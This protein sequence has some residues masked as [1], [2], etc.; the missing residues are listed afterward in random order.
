VVAVSAVVNVR[1]GTA[2]Q[3]AHRPEPDEA[4]S[5]QDA[6]DAPKLA[7]LLTRILR[8]VA[9]LKRPFAPRRVSF[10]DLTV[11]GTG[12][13]KYRLPHGFG[14]RVHWFVADWSG[15]A[16]GAGLERHSDTDKDTL[17][18]VS[19]VAGLASVRIEEAG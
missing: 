12:T 6:A 17:V 8:D 10:V 14:A 15:A 18:L 3:L 5:E 16:A 19:H 11:D 7:R 2:R 13:T 4:I 1:T 9:A